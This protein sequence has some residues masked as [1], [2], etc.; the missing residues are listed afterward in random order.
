M[1]VVRLHLGMCAP[2]CAGLQAGAEPSGA[3]ST[4]MDKPDLATSTARRSLAQ[5]IERSIDA[6]EGARRG[7]TQLEANHIVTAIGCLRQDLCRD[8]EAILHFAENGW[9]QELVEPSDS[10]PTVRQLR[11]ML[12]EAVGEPG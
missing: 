9:G 6:I 4:A 12:A 8:G 1:G 7:P 5:R 3:V 10:L 11:D 2:S